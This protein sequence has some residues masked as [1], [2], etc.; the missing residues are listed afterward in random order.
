MFGPSS[1]A[2][3]APSGALRSRSAA[4]SGTN[5]RVKS[6]KPLSPVRSTTGRFCIRPIYQLRYDMGQRMP[7][8]VGILPRHALYRDVPFVVACVR[9]HLIARAIDSEDQR[10]H[11]ALFGMHLEV[12]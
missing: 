4:P 5:S 8:S 1:G 3:G 9:R 12:E 6:Q 10:L 11:G 7:L 2:S